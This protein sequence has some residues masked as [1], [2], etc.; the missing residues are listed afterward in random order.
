MNGRKR[1]RPKSRSDWQTRIQQTDD[2]F[3]FLGA[4]VN[5]NS[6]LLSMTVWRVR[7]AKAAFFLWV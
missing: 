5:V 1:W 3:P 7:R 4:T 6:L 2:R